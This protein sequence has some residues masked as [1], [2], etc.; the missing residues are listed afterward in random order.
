MA[1][2]GAINRLLSKKAVNIVN[3]QDKYSSELCALNAK[4]AYLFEDDCDLPS[5]EWDQQ[6]NELK[7]LRVTLQNK[8]EIHIVAEEAIGE[9]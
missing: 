1:A 4:Y 5:Y 8:Y 6:F 7:S 3:A 9:D 2:V